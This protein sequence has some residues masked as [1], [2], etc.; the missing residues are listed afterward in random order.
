MDIVIIGGGAAGF[1]AAINVKMKLPSCKVII[2]EQAKNVL[3]KVRISG[4]GRCNVTHACFD[5][6]LLTTYYPRGHKELLG[7]FHVFGASETVAWFEAQK[8][9]LYTEPDGCMF[10]VANTS[11]V[12][13]DC[14]M[15][16]VKT[17]HIEVVTQTKVKDIQLS[18][19]DKPIYTIQTESGVIQSDYLM[20]ATGSSPFMWQVLANLGYKIIKPVPSLFTF[21]LPQHPI[22]ALMGLVVE[23]A[24][25]N[26]KDTKIFTDGPLL[27]THWGLSGPA[28]LKASAWA[29][30]ILNERNYDFEVLVDWLPHIEESEIKNLK[31][32][33]AKK[34]VVANS[35]FGLPY[36]LWHFLSQSII[37]DV[38]KNWASL[39][40]TELTDLVQQLKQCSFKVSGK[41]TFKEEFVTA[42]G[43]D[44]AQIHFK[45][46]ESKLHAGLYMAGEAINIDAVTGGFNF[47]AAWTGAYIAAQDMAHKIAS[48]LEDQQSF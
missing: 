38:D 17:L 32:H 46:F 9:K 28:I 43:V 15:K 34:K 31:I 20:I 44:L 16:L 1:F 3:N 37:T 6:K 10:P 22:C 42:G 7:P 40:K 12:I 47:Q 13:I 24:R 36:R 14:F 26:I 8:V 4:G 23:N 29:A 39:T 2:I 21:N 18:T 33:M 11:E 27:I 25:V 35:V 48:R 5:P 41:T 30:T 45:T 19:H